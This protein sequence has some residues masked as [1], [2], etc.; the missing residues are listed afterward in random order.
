[1]E[2]SRMVILCGRCNMKMGEVSLN[3][4]EF[5]EGI[6]LDNVKV[7]R[8]LLGHVTFTEEQALEVEQ[9]TEHLRTKLHHGRTKKGS[10]S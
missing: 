3:S 5:E 1:M 4:Y 2:A 9:R 6:T 10:M 7:M 8:C